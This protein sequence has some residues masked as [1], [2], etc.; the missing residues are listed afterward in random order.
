[1]CC[2]HSSWIA[3]Y[4]LDIWSNDFNVHSMYFG[5][6]TDLTSYIVC[7]AVDSDS[8]NIV[9]C[10]LRASVGQFLLSSV[11]CVCWHCCSAVTSGVLVLWVAGS[12][13]S[14]FPAALHWY[15]CYV[16]YYLSNQFMVNKILLLLLSH[17][18]PEIHA[19]SQNVNTRPS[20]YRCLDIK[21][22]ISWRS[23]DVKVHTF[24]II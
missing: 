11:Q 14:G 3:E 4:L 8:F 15:F 16:S 21:A 12:D 10:W 6:K 23:V 9:Q 20:K 24:V 2:V 5:F 19:Q 17:S 22:Y 13:V 1:M 7:S 18:Y